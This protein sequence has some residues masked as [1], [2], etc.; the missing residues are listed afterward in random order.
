MT[1]PA[2]ARPPAPPTTPGASAPAAPSAA[3]AAQPRPTSLG[4]GLLVMGDLWNLLLVRSLLTG[5][6]ARFLDLKAALGISDPVL[7]RRLRDLAADGVI[8]GEEYTA[9]PPRLEYRLTGTGADLWPVYVAL[10]VW[11][12]RWAPASPLRLHAA[13]RHAKCGRRTDPVFG[14]GAC[15]AIG[16]SA[17][18]TAAEVDTSI[19]FASANPR[20]RYHRSASA[21]GAAG[22]PS[23]STGTGAGAAAAASAGAAAGTASA[24]VLADRTS[25]SLLAAA[26]LGNHRFGDFQALLHD[27]APQTLTARLGLLTEQAILAKTPLR[28]GG[29]RHGYRLTPKG[30]DFFPTF[31][32]LIAWSGRRFQDDGRPGVAIVHRACGQPLVPRW[33]CNACNEPLDGAE[34][35]ADA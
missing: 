20:R 17:R 15:G 8:A 4:H 3:P 24:A 31:A 19:P 1:S 21:A 28:E 23:A 5:G 34:F 32:F 18:D 2:A 9:S 11:D 25:T 14:C 29:R 33:T 13:L 26:F 35:T 27:T 6:P 7:S 22:D 10:H 30:H 16:L 12:R